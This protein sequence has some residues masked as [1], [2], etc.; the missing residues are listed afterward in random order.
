MKHLTVQSFLL[1]SVILL[2]HELTKN[3]VSAIP[4]LMLCN[5]KCFNGGTILM[6]T[7]IF[8]YCHCLCRKGF[9]GPRCEIAPKNMKLRMNLKLFLKRLRSRWPR[10]QY[11]GECQHQY[12][13]SINNVF[14]KEMTVKHVRNH[15]KNIVPIW[16]PRDC[17]D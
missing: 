17:N 12:V 1:I 16:L 15:F 4:A 9:A 8:G 13:I 2:S 11:L 3:S 14:N 5:G 7:S 10:K 6:P